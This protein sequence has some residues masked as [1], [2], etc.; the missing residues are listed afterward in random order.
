MMNEIDNHDVLA[1]KEGKDVFI[2]V[3]LTTHCVIIR[4]SIPIRVWCNTN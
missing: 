1:Q 4:M 2:K 3:Q